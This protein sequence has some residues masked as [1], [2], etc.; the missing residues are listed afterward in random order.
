MN[1]SIQRYRHDLLLISFIFQIAML[2]ILVP[3][4]WGAIYQCTDRGG[5]TVY[6]DSPA[7]LRHCRVLSMEGAQTPNF[8]GTAEHQHLV[9][10]IGIPG[11]HPQAPPPDMAAKESMA[12]LPPPLDFSGGGVPRSIPETNVF[13]DLLSGLPPRDIFLQGFEL[14]SDI[15][16]HQFMTP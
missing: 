3:S 4:S 6:T 7:Q 11:F 16:Q 12:E 10:M 9:D 2:V 5:A 13:E 15:D 1:Q 8:T 14:P